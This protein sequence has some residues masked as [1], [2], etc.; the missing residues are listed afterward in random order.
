M[1]ADFVRSSIL[2]DVNI[3]RR[4]GIRE[5]TKACNTSLTRQGKG[6]RNETFDRK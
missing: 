4:F 5:K 6:Y 2:E 3:I 1:Y